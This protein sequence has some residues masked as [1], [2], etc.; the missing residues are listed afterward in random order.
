MKIA[1]IIFLSCTLAAKAFPAIHQQHSLQFT[2]KYDRKD[3]LYSNLLLDVLPDRFKLDRPLD[4]WQRQALLARMANRGLRTDQQWQ[5]TDTTSNLLLPG[6]SGAPKCPIQ[7]PPFP[8]SCRQ[9]T[10]SGTSNRTTLGPRGPI[11]RDIKVIA[12]MGDS[13]TCGMFMRGSKATILAHLLGGKTEDRSHAF[14]AGGGEG[15][16]TLATN[17]WHFADDLT[18]AS[19]TDT[20]SGTLASELPLQELDLAVISTPIEELTVQAAELVHRLNQPAFAAYRQHWK[21]INIFGSAINLCRSCLPDWKERT[22]VDAIGRSLDYLLQYLQDNLP[23]AD[24]GSLK[25]LINVFTMFEQPSTIYHL[26]GADPWCRR[27]QKAGDICS[28]LYDSDSER[29]RLDQLTTAY[30]QRLVDIVHKWQR[31]LLADRLQLKV[32]AVRAMEQ[33]DFKSLGAAYISPTDCFHPNECFNRLVTFLSWQQIVLGDDS[34]HLI[35]NNSSFQ[36]DD[37]ERYANSILLA[38]N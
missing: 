6:R 13:V 20:K 4:Q 8:S 27:I 10:G 31:S 36:W 29:L 30:N 1:A 22:T 24:D 19:L 16:L 3:E 35:N 12:A 26:F 7:I 2:E 17:L 11:L 25:V 14:A 5:Q 37:C 21:M 9:R 38:R 23:R 32:S 18:G 15:A 33:I 34:K 28:C